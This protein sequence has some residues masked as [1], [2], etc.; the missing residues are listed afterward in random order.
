MRHALM[1]VSC[2]DHQL[3]ME[4]QSAYMF[5]LIGVTFD[6]MLGVFRDYLLCVTVSTRA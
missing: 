2:T 1:R 5:D 6:I 4:W 3:V